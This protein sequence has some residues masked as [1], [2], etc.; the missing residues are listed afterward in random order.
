MYP[1]DAPS[2]V[3]VSRYVGTVMAELAAT[4]IFYIALKIIHFL[5]W[6]HFYL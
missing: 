4:L 3:E 1:P 6:G 2:D 5:V